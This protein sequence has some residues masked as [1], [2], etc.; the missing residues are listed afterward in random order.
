[1]VVVGTDDPPPGCVSFDALVARSAPLLDAAPREDDDIA[2][3]LYT[4]GTTGKPK[5]VIQT[6]KNLYSNARNGWNSATTRDRSEIVLLVLP[7]AHTFGLSALISGYLFGNK[8]ILMRWFDPE[9]A[10][11]L[12]EQHK[13]TFMAG[14]PTMFVMMTMHPNATKY[15]TSS[16]RRWLV[17]AAPMPMPQLREFEQKFGGMMDSVVRPFSRKLSSQ[18]RRRARG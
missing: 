8:G 10:L 18:R 17:G 12:I 9:G 13:V 14:V 15:D 2:T 11:A 6:H 16:V 3:I 5:G 4:S 1:M 7:L